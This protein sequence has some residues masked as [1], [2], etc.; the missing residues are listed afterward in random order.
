LITREYNKEHQ[1]FRNFDDKTESIVQMLGITP[2][3]TVPDF[4]CG[5]GGIAL[6]IEKYCKKLPYSTF[7]TAGGY[8]VNSFKL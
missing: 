6:N 8:W 3:D 2:E 7:S 4:G 5:T 1:K